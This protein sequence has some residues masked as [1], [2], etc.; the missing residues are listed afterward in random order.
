MRLA[1]WTLGLILPPDIVQ[2]GTERSTAVRRE[3]FEPDQVVFRQGE[4]G[5]RLDV[6][7][8]GEVEV[9][10]GDAERGE[11]VLQRLGPG[12]SFGEI[13]LVS[14]R[15]RTATVR[16]VGRVNVVLPAPP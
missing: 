11:V 4:R 2:L 14:D 5:D 9:V 1:G 16:S 10:C 13:A 3:R 12:E 8:D 7:V 15:P 6:I